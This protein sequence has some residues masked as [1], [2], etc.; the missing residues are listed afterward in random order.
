LNLAP[1]GFTLK[2]DRIIKTHIITNAVTMH[3]DIR[4]KLLPRSSKSQIMGKEGDMYKVKVN[5]P[6]VDGE[7]NKEL[8]SLLSKKL[9]Q[10]KKNIEII[11]GKT[12]R[13]KVV[14]IY[15]ISEEE[16]SGLLD[17]R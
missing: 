13:M 7:A 3:T 4:I 15:G 17:F 6:P 5:S 10:P 2:A 16:L 8:I 11:T 14:R 9:G 1:T 12:S